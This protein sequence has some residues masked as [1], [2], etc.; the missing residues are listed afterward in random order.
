MGILAAGTGA[1][2]KKIIEGNSTWLPYATSSYNA[3]KLIIFG[4]ISSGIG[5]GFGLILGIIF[6]FANISPRNAYFNDTYNW[7]KGQDIDQDL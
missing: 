6:Y 1:I 5:L 2:G 3:S 4:L 7:R